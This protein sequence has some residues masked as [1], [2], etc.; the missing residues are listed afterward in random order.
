MNSASRIYRFASRLVVF[1][2][3]WLIVGTPPKLHA[4]MTSVVDSPVDDEFAYA[5][6]DTL[7]ENID[8][9]IDGI[10]MDEKRRCTLRAA[11][12]E[13]S[14]IGVAANVSF[15]L[16]GSSIITIANPLRP[17]APPDGSIISG[18]G[19]VQIAG[20]GSF[21]FLMFL[22]NNTTVQGMHF[23]DA[24][25]AI[26]VVGTGNLIG[27]NMNQNQ[28]NTFKNMAQAAI[29]LIGDNNLVKGNFIGVDYNGNVDGNQFGVF[30]TNSS[31]NIIGGALPG[32]GNVISGNNTGIALV[33]DSL[34]GH[35]TVGKNEIIGNLIGTDRT[36]TIKK[37]NQYG[38]SVGF[39]HALTI[40]SLVHPGKRNI[41]SG[42]SVSG[43]TLG[44]NADTIFIAGNYIGT[45]ITGVYGLGNQT[46]MQLGPGSKNSIVVS[47]LIS[48]NTAEGITISGYESPIDLPS[49]HHV[50]TGNTIVLNELGGVKID[51][52]ATDNIIGS[53]LTQN[54]TPN[55][56]QYNG[57]RGSFASSAGIS[58]RG[59]SGLGIPRAN[60]IR[61]NDFLDN[62]PRGVILVQPPAVQDAIK[63]PILRVYVVYG[64]G[65]A[66][67]SG[68]HHRPGSL[69]DVYSAGA[70]IGPTFQG[71]Q[72]LASGYVDGNGDFSVSMDS[73]TC[74]RLIATATDAAGNT[75]EFSRS[76]ATR[77]GVLTPNHNIG[78]N[79]QSVPVGT[80]GTVNSLYP[81]ATSQAYTWIGPTNVPGTLAKNTSGSYVPQDTLRRGVG[82]WI[83]FGNS[84][85]DSL[86]GS[87]QTEDTINVS[88]G[89]NL[90]SSISDPVAVSEI[91]SIPG[92]LTTSQ[93]FGYTTSYEVVDTIQP[94]K[95][96]WVKVNQ[97]GSLVLASP[98][99]PLLD[100]LITIVPDTALPPP[101]PPEVLGNA[102]IAQV[103]LN[104]GWNMASVPVVV[105]DFQTSALFP[106][107]TTT[108]YAY[109]SGSYAPKTT[110]TNGPGYWT[111]YGS[112]TAVSMTGA[113]ITSDT[114][115]VSL[116]W[117]LIG[118]ISSPLAVP[119]IT[120]NP[121]G[122]ITSPFYGFNLSYFN[123]DT[124]R[125][126][127]AYWV[128]TSGAGS[129]ML[130]S[131]G[132]I[133]SSN[134]IRIRPSSELPPP[135]P[136]NSRNPTSN[137][138]QEFS[139]YQNFPNPFNPSTEFRFDI[140][141]SG[142]VSLRV[143]DVLGR[144][145][146]TLVNEELSPGSYAKTWDASAVPSGL[147]YYKLT[148]GTFTDVK[149]MVVM[150]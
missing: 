60:T 139:L 82:Y 39:H 3:C 125:P 89:W 58:I 112:G 95:A 143:Y 106:G 57:T 11:L 12:E 145:L 127:K 79:M 107:T 138:P 102:T 17:F 134:R 96:Y 6:D 69:I 8:E 83:K 94:G 1:F 81:G 110:L 64:D 108:V 34:D 56:I 68:T 50:I 109:E 141:V 13:A 104:A 61:K 105:S 130:S 19:V 66:I 86:T 80:S 7:T 65:T 121:G 97:G 23:N 76:F 46:G 98:D 118:S 77:P 36:G 25:E 113:P 70:V 2:C 40:G 16:T 14:A 122:M 38:I 22:G 47:N 71:R 55:V 29:N 9:S 5:W 78:A 26:V 137:I 147:Y 117:N 131:S 100:S 103:N 54:F 59:F 18:N 41:I 63:A 44:A 116:G 135:P 133:P 140:P 62:V 32:E 49:T 30:V 84:G 149:K 120:S 146:A 124:I 87:I 45:D 10:C 27:G 75:S 74:S 123:A 43:I 129:L 126:G 73:C 4:Q 42:N 24:T 111:K 53:S 37:P 93:F 28:G 72:W 92:G 150:K 51:Y 33:G 31:L 48:S 88:A 85:T 101:P 21:S 115:N 90:I 52:H 132:N 136:G 91:A 128:K 20:S 119:S 148:A 144:V 15:S 114:F 35:L 67:I 99:G 142:F